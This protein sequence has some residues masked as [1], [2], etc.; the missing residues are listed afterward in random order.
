M[1]ETKTLQMIFA[2][3]ASGRV[4]ISILD[5][6]EDLTAEIVGAAMNDIITANIINSTGGD[7]VSV[8]GARVVARQVTELVS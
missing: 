7:L 1:E 8:I 3:A 2:N 4:T 5:P 6:R